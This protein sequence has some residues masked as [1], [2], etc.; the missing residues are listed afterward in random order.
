MQRPSGGVSQALFAATMICL[1]CVG[2]YLND[3]APVLEPV[4]EYIPARQSLIYLAELLPL[5]TGLGLFWWRSAALASRTLFAFLA[6]WLI[7][8]KLPA[9]VLAPT[10][11]ESWSGSGETLV[12]VAAAWVIYIWCA[13]DLESRYLGFLTS[14][15]AIRI[16][17]TCYGLALLPF[18]IAHFVYLTETVQLVPTWLPVPL[19]WAIA[20]GCAFILAGVAII[21]DRHAA[22]AARLSVLQIGGFT[23]LVWVP[24]IAA[25]SNSRFQWSET[26]ISFAL[27][28]SAM[29]VATS[30]Q[31]RSPH[32]S[33]GSL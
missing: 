17:R 27:T 2:F 23:L 22:L 8:M 7:A 19:A 24:I 3:F 32:G 21:I 16:A 14:T 1:G 13:A 10:S 11:Q 5:I 25:G 20:T 6:I 28:V 18:G 29:V 26:V 30:Y 33:N 31:K 12:V 15:P 9:I 4:Q